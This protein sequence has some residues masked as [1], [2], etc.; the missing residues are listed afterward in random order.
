MSF[1]MKLQLAH[2]FAYLVKAFLPACCHPSV[3]L[4]LGQ[5]LRPVCVSLKLARCYIITIKS[6]IPTSKTSLH[7]FA[8]HSEW[9]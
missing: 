7:F 4:C 5:P 3:L 9:S 6:S 1:H 2:N 8:K